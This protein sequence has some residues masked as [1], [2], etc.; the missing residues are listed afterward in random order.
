MTPGTL[1]WIDSLDEAGRQQAQALVVDLEQKERA[2]EQI[3]RRL[4]EL[5]HENSL[6][7]EET[8][9]LRI[10]KYGRKSEALSDGQLEL[11]DA[12]PGVQA[13]EVE[14]EAQ[15]AP[16]PGASAPRKASPR[17]HPGREELPAHLPRREE[18]L[19]VEGQERLCPC[20]GKERC[21][22]GYEKRELLDVIPAQYFVREIKREK[23]ACH[24]HPEAGV[25]T[26]APGGPRIVEKGKLSDGLI[27]DVGIKKYDDHQPLYRQRAILARDHQVELAESTLCDGVLALGALYVPVAAAMR[28]ELFAGGYI[29][30]DET[31]VGVQSEQ[32]RGRNHTGYIFQYSR[33]GG[34]VVYDFRMSRARE[35]PREFLKGY[36]GLLQTDGYAGYNNVGAEGLVHAACLAHVRRKFHDQLKLDPQNAQAKAILGIIAAIADVEEQ[37]RQARLDA[38]ARLAL[39]KEQSAPLMQSLQEKIQEV[40]SRVLPSSVLGKACNYALGQ[41]KRLERF[42]E[43]GELEVDNNWCENGMRNVVLGRKNW[44]HIGSE[45]AGPKI[46]ALQSVLETCKRNGINVREYLLDVAPRLADWPVKRVGE[47]TPLRWK[48]DREKKQ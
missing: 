9:L 25:V 37:A 34:P 6:L 14:L 2:L 12:E 21:L 40:K 42:L 8:R 27:I 15:R 24:E 39:R 46:A 23:L 36:G 20:C 44:M 45:K 1:S 35:G 28:S 32:T 10:A 22:I 48:A 47:L 41:W 4:Q 30:A 38:P 18:V 26:A 7:L 19:R 3:T 29:Q 5:E 17:K 11:L 33:P 13:Q 43:Y 31:P 16:L